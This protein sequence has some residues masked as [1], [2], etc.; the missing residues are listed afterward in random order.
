M[1]SDPQ[2][3]LE[4][5]DL[6]PSMT[7]ADFGAGSGHF[8][9]RAARMVGHSGRVYAIDV[10]KQVLANLANEARL[11]H[12]KHLD[13]IWADLEKP[14]SSHLRAHTIDRALVVNVLFQ[15]THKDALVEEIARV[16]RPHGK[17]L[18]IDWDDATMKFGP[19][20]NSV[21]PH[22]AARALFEK[23]GFEYERMINAGA[24]HYGMIFSR[25]IS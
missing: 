9:L 1:F 20:R 14:H 24:H 15:L 10:Q 18:V 4:Q 12:I 19:D 17:V 6:M 2:K 5:F 22:T 3:N 11:A 8:A 16:L 25:K 13:T 23:H 21:V 7:V